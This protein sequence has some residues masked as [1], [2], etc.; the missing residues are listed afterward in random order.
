MYLNLTYFQVCKL[1]LSHKLPEL[2]K[3]LFDSFQFLLLWKT[4]DFFLF[5]EMFV[6][7]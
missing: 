2:I 1:N 6:H 5:K 7:V 3:I 4:V